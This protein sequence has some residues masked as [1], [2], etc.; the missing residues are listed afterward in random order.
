M[1]LPDPIPKLTPR[2][3][4]MPEDLRRTAF[5]EQRVLPAT[6]RGSLPLS[7]SRRGVVGY[8]SSEILD[9]LDNDRR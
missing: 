2:H 8:N 6:G 7:P 9:P 1:P 5:R 4:W 3:Q